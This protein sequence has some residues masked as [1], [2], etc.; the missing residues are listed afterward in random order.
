MKKLTLFLTLAAALALTQS[1]CATSASKVPAVSPKPA[2]QVNT[3]RWQDQILQ[4]ITSESTGLTINNDNHQLV[5]ISGRFSQSDWRWI[6]G[7][8]FVAALNTNTTELIAWHINLDTHATTE[9]ARYH[10]NR[11]DQ[12]TL[13]LYQHD[14][15]IDAFIADASGMLSQ[16]VLQSNTVTGPVAIRTLATGT[17]IKAC[18]VNDTTN[19]LYLADENAGVWQYSAWQEAEPDRKLLFHSPGIAVEGVAVT[20]DGHLFWSSPDK[21]TLWQQQ[22]DG[23]VNTY[24]LPEHLKVEAIS[25]DRVDEHIITGLYDDRT[26]RTVMRSF[27]VPERPAHFASIPPADAHLMASVQT[28]PVTRAGDAADDPAIWVNTDHP[29]NSLILGT[30]KKA[31]LYSYTLDGRQ[32][33]FLPAGRLN[34]VDVRYQF[35]IGS[36]EVD[37]AVA[38]NRSDNTLAVFTIA[39]QTGRL[40]LAASLPT[41]LSD[42][43]GLCMAK[44]D[45]RFYVIVNDTDGR[46]EQYEISPAGNSITGTLVRQFQTRTQPEGCVADDVT[47]MLY[48]GEEGVGIW[49]RPLRSE[50]APQQIASVNHP[51]IAADIE[52]LALIKVDNATYLL[53]SSQGN[54]RYAVYALHSHRLVGTF[55]IQ[56]NTAAG[57]DGVSETDGLDATSLALGPRFPDGLL[58]VQDG[59]NV[60]PSA[61]QNFKLVDG[62]ALAGVI[63]RLVASNKH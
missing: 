54:H 4:L 50:S 30:D 22:P 24:T 42:V 39:P 3:L 55:D 32:H 60:M 5:T 28:S 7:Q 25:A 10:I 17:G 8:L 37:I 58:V 26:Q 31:G 53:A 40:T 14:N 21:P 36:T 20:A 35:A 33:Q 57:I 13:C 38:S 27:T 18:A 44:V 48:Y 9:V 59:H 43:Y 52:G 56:E 61:N 23:R 6:N 62:K 2:N 49:Q 11:A 47:G 46:F 19:T 15:R 45:N 1:A 29:H 63:R 34:N 51:A 41:G 16:V 12:E